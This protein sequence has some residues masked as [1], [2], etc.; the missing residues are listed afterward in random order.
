[1]SE[2]ALRAAGTW[3][4]TN[5]FWLFWARVTL[6]ESRTTTNADRS[7]KLLCSGLHVR[8]GRSRGLMSISHARKLTCLS[9]GMLQIPYEAVE[10]IARIARRAKL[11]FV[12]VGCLSRNP[13][14]SSGS[15]TQA[16]KVP[17]ARNNWKPNRC[18]WPGSRKATLFQRA[19]F[20]Q[21]VPVP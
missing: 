20:E 2:G 19:R 8:H 16:R 17:P 15:Q 14:M 1:M 6:V 10:P 9:I 5:S 12:L 21:L 18:V 4:M 13:S 3:N 11:L 7:G